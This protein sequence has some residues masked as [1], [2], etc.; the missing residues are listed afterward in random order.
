MDEERVARLR[1]RLRRRVERERSERV[2]VRPRYDETFA[3][4]TAWLNSMAGGPPVDEE[5]HQH[6]CPECGKD[7][8][9]RCGDL[10]EEGGSIP[11]AKLCR[12]CESKEWIAEKRRYA[13][14]QPTVQALVEIDIRKRIDPDYED[15][16]CE[17]EALWEQRSKEIEAALPRPCCC[18]ELSDTR[19]VYLRRHPQADTRPESPEKWERYKPEWRMSFSYHIALLWRDQGVSARALFC[20]FCGTRLPEVRRKADP[21]QPLC[22]IEDGGYRC[23]TCGEARD[24]I[25]YPPEAAYEI[26]EEGDEQS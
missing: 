7:W 25:C 4:G 20:P 2:A 13:G 15:E 5:T 1:S 23:S 16:D 26:V 21:P 22:V 9:C 19:A 24:C 14:D 12:A 11:K 6:T 17:A 18:K 8:D 10:C 3:K